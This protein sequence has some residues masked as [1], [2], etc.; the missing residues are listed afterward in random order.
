MFFSLLAKLKEMRPLAINDRTRVLVL[1]GAGVSAE[2]G[3]PTF[4][5]ADGLWRSHRF[6]EVAS[7]DGFHRDPQL[8]WQFY[9]ERRQGLQSAE[10][11]D[12][13]KSLASLE[14]RLG[15]RFLLVTQNVDGLH[16]RAGSK[17]VI[18]MHG[19][20]LKSRCSGCDRAPF[21]D[22]A[23]YPDTLPQCSECRAEGRDA[24]LR[25][26]I[27][28]FG[29]GLD[30]ALMTRVRNFMSDAGDQLIFLAVG[31]S[32]NVF[33]AALLVDDARAIGGHTILVNRD[34]AANATHFD[35]VIRGKSGEILPVLLALD[36]T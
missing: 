19:S 21:Y 13:H 26:H 24:L 18:E 34:E 17:R 22:P 29:E 25:P 11:N 15:G 36:E 3:I 7:P 10:P 23:L 8:V 28:W 2:S 5:D 32:G 12:G 27:V 20:L 30:L 16:Q 35:Q 33:P 14:A 31:T 9:S 4:R 1:T 6:E